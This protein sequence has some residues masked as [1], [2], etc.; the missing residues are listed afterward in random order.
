M[1]GALLLL[2]FLTACTKNS[3]TVTP[4]APIMSTPAYVQRIAVTPL[5][6]PSSSAS[7]AKHWRFTSAL[8]KKPK[9][10]FRWHRTIGRR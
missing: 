7:P 6:S 5:P 2:I 8:F 9:I 4:A 3:L 10:K 1:K